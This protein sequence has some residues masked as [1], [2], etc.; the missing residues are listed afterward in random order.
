M[1]IQDWSDEITVVDLGS[2]PLFTDELTGLTEQLEDK[3]TD[4]VL[5]FAAVSFINS[6]N[7]AKL[8]KLRKTMLAIKHRL[9]MCGINADVWGVFGVTGLDKIFTFT[10]DISTALATLQLPAKERSS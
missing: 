2:D 6:S 9:I 7:I 8:L 10:N 1:A 5:N 3:P 4:V